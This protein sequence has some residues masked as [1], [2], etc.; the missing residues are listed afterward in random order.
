[1]GGVAFCHELIFLITLGKY[2]TQAF[3]EYCLGIHRVCGDSDTRLFFFLL[4]KMEIV[5]T[6]GETRVFID[7]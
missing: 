6:L 3:H 2:S 4:P 1:M 7:N 5:K